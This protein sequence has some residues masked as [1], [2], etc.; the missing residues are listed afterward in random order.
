MTKS[1]ITIAFRSL[2]RRK[3]HSSVN[4][5][6]LSVGLTAFLLISLWVQDELSYDTWIENADRIYRVVTSIN[7]SHGPLEMAMTPPPTGAALRTLPGVE[8][9]T[10]LIGPGKSVVVRVGDDVFN[11][12]DCFCADSTL[13]SVFALPFEEGNPRTALSTPNSVVLTAPLARKYFGDS[14]AIGK[15]LNIEWYGANV[16]VVVRGVMKPMPRNSHFH[17]SLVMPIASLGAEELPPVWLSVSV[18]TY[19]LLGSHV[20]P[21]TVESDLPLLLREHMDTAVQNFWSLH[22]QSIEGIHLHSHLLL[23]MEP[24]GDFFTVLI[25]GSVGIL[26]IC[27]AVMNFVSMTTARYN[28]RVKEVGVRKALGAERRDLIVQFMWEY[29]TVVI[30]AMILAATAGE[31]VLPGFS[32]LVGK[33]LVVMPVTLAIILVA[34]L[35]IAS[36]GIFYPAI[37]LSSLHPG[38]ALRK[39][40]IPL[41]AGTSLR[42]V[43][44]VLQFAI[45]IG[46]IAIAIVVKSQMAYVR[47]KDLGINVN[48]TLLIPLRQPELRAKYETLKQECSR[49]PGVSGISASS[50]PPSDMN[51]INSLAYHNESILSVRSLAVDYDFL[52]TMGVPMVSGRD[53][54]RDMPS[55]LQGGILVNESGAKQLEQEHLLDKP[56]EFDV[57]RLGR[58]HNTVIGVV[59]DFHYRPLYYPVEPV[60]LYLH[61]ADL[62]FMLVRVSAQNSEV[63]LHELEQRWKAIVPAYPF[64]FS[65]LDQNLER[66]YASVARTQNILTLFSGLAVFIACLGLF[67]LAAYDVEKRSKEIGIRKVLGASVHHIVATLA[68]EFAL[69]I[70]IAGI[71]A[72]PLSYWFVHIWLDMFSYRINPGAWVFVLSVAGVFAVSMATVAYQARKAATANPLDS[73]RCE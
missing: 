44:L 14:P 35:A 34:G 59:K 4:I 8:E 27:I 17:L 9:V 65:F 68:K 38:T 71:I 51:A 66:T 49:I 63:V 69:M 46:L 62:R 45:A 19:A 3:L 47:S 25:F 55:D 33:T 73:L 42:K 18:Y 1:F 37:V 36:L 53:F 56:L 29:G 50:S 2:A 39:S 7:D 72:I 13:F 61:P 5:L 30:I 60:M 31:C 52:K 43:L 12:Q 28:D 23:E 41:S 64:E 54:S 6:G 70:V 22:V 40:V 15:T 67:G 58:I 57:S 26:I 32:Q 20:L 48:H 21:S 10:R 24:N 11:E 16:D